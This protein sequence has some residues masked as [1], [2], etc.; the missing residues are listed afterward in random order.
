MGQSPLFMRPLNEVM[1]GGR[2]HRAR[3]IC[4]RSYIAP[5][6]FKVAVFLLLGG[7]G[8][9][10]LIGCGDD[11]ASPSN[12]APEITDI[13]AEPDTIAVG[14][15]SQI[16]CFADDPDGD[17]LTYSW[18]ALFGTLTGS[19]ANVIWT[20]PDSAE[21]Y[22]VSVTVEDAHGA[23]AT[24]SVMVVVRDLIEVI[25]Q[26]NLPEWDGGWTHVNPTPEGSALMW[27]TFMPGHPNLTAVEISVLIANPR[28]GGDTLTVEIAES[29]NILA[30]AKSYVEEGFEGLV[31]FDFPEAVTL[32]PDQTYELIVYDTGIT[33]FGWKYGPNDYDRGT[34]YASGEEQPGTDWLF[35]TYSQ[36]LSITAE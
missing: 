29:G 31:R 15:D 35:R 5:R 12:H 33:E 19:A 4:F 2:A 9:L 3:S 1:P 11:G 25:D 16:T 17:D 14:G 32:V 10:P 36:V 8:L 18:G 7:A 13:V 27:Q 23:T 22:F 24:D 34:R 6:A 30:S 26:S 21:D 28:V 20:A